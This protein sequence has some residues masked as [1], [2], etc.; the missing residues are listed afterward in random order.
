MAVPP[1]P[2]FPD[3][4]GPPSQEGPDHPPWVPPSGG[5]PGPDH[6]TG[7]PP[8]DGHFWPGQSA[9]SPPAAAPGGAGVPQFAAYPVRKRRGPLI[10]GVVAGALSGD[11]VEI[12]GSFSR[13]EAEGV[14]RRILGTA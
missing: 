3:P 10:A 8:P 6:P 13:Q 12:S 1:G 7:F 9:G 14:V 2:A 5:P 11:D 4:P